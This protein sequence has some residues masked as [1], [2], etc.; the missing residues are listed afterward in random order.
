MDSRARRFVRFLLHRHTR[1]VLAWLLTLPVGIAVLTVAW[2][3]FDTPKGEDGKPLRP[4]GNKGH[5]TID[6]GGQWLIGR[7]L[8]LGQGRHLYH[9][10]YQRAVLKA[11]LPIEDEEPPDPAT[12]EKVA[13]DADA[14]MEWLMGTDG[15]TIQ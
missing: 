5:T 3:M 9:R 7:L 15:P 11:A 6:F 4:G 2:T 12:K 1:Y 10:N 13:H 8:V 14:L